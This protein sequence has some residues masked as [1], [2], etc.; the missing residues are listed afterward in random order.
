MSV[1]TKYKGKTKHSLLE[2][3]EMVEQRDEEIHQLYAESGG[4]VAMIRNSLGSVTSLMSL[5]EIM[6]LHTD[7]DDTKLKYCRSK[8][9]D[10][11][12]SAKESIK[13]I[14]SL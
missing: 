1:I 6:Y 9:P 2:L 5:V 13:Y 14:K 4:I 10:Q 3:E 7:E 11:L 12:K 8:I